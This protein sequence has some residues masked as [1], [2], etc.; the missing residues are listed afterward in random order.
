MRHAFY[1][2][3]LSTGCTW[4]S[5]E[6]LET[7]KQGSDNDGDGFIFTDD[8]NDSDPNINPAAVEEWYNG[9]DQNC[10]GLNDYDADGDGYVAPGYEGAL[11]DNNPDTVINQGGDCND[12]DS[13][14]FPDAIEVW[15]DGVDQDCGG[16]K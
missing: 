2:A 15:Y 14:V 4:I 13:A 8:C 7:A 3:L 1:I 9:I 10:D 12:E 5:Y 16:E 6:E 11:T